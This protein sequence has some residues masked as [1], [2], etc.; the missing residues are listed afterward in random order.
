MCMPWNLHAMYDYSLIKM[1]LKHTLV[2][3][4]NYNIKSMSKYDLFIYEVGRKLISKFLWKLVN[5]NNGHMTQSGFP[6]GITVYDVRG[7]SF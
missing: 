3:L 5:L 1:I 7:M 6:S 2:H 4:Q